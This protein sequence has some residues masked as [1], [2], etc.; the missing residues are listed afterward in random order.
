MIRIF[1]LSLLFTL[2]LLFAATLAAAPFEDSGTCGMPCCRQ[3]WSIT[4]AS[5]EEFVTALQTT[6]KHGGPDGHYS[7]GGM[8]VTEG[9]PYTAKFF[10]TTE[11]YTYT[12]LL[13]FA[14]NNGTAPG[15]AQVT[16][17]SISQVVQAYQDNGQNH[18]NLDT[19]LTGMAKEFQW[20]MASSKT[21]FGCGKP[22]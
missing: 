11:A 1:G 3:T 10:H 19:L 9:L 18:K 14:I 8:D 20:R 15:T 5:A 22:Q 7:W 21:D 17:F 16:A 6:V 12:D 13:N 4:G 2:S